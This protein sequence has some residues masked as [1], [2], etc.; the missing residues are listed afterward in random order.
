MKGVDLHRENMGINKL[1]EVSNM[2]VVPKENALQQMEE[3]ISSFDLLETNIALRVNHVLQYK[4]NQV[5][6]YAEIIAVRVTH[7]EEKLTRHSEEGW[8]L[9]TYMHALPVV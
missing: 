7:M 2:K 4:E 8:W 5:L 3:L 6:E 1:K 9:R